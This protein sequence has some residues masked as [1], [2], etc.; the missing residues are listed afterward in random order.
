MEREGSWIFL[1]ILLHASTSRSLHILPVTSLL[2][3]TVGQCGSDL[4]S[5]FTRCFIQSAW[6]KQTSYLPLLTPHCI[7]ILQQGWQK[8]SLPFCMIDFWLRRCAETRKWFY[9][10]KN[11]ICPHKSTLLNK[12]LILLVGKYLEVNC[13]KYIKSYERS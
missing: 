5:C 4:H 1:D 13:K 6:G 9:F 8:R 10:F 7:P 11:A 12:P 3:R 2:L